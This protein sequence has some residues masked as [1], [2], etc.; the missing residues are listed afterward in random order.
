MY[1]VTCNKPKLC[2]VFKS[3]Y[4]SEVSFVP[5]AKSVRSN[6][7]PVCSSTDIANDLRN[8]LKECFSVKDVF[9]FIN[10]FNIQSTTLNR[11]TSG[12]GYFDPIKRRNLL[13]E[14][15]VSQTVTPSYKSCEILTRLSSEIY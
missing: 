7:E 3:R 6:F 9:L 15:I 13:T 5:A 11:A 8:S 10:R 14:N 4:I 2:R 1:C 12:P